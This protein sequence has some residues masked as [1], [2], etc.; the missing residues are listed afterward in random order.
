M[1]RSL[2]SIVLPRTW[3]PLR[4]EHWLRAQCGRGEMD[5]QSREEEGWRGWEVRMK[6]G[7]VKKP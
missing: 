5:E 4:D 1:D 2:H 3:A 7:V 6:N